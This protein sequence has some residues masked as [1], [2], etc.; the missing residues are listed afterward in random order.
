MTI[1]QT[2]FCQ[3]RQMQDRSGSQHVKLSFMFEN[4]TISNAFFSMEHFFCG[5]RALQPPNETASQ[6]T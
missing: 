5:I 3:I 1:T 2:N 6:E 4:K